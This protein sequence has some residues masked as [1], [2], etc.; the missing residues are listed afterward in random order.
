MGRPGGSFDDFVK[1]NL[2]TNGKAG[3]GNIK[4]P[5]KGPGCACVLL[6]FLAGVIITGRFR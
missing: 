1:F 4:A 6:L 2:M 5:G 3:G